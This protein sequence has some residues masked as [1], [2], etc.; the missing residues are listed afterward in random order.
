MNARILLAI[1]ALAVAPSFASAEEVIIRDRVPDVTIERPPAV[2]IERPAGRVEERGT[3][4]LR[5]DDCKRT[6]IH[7]ES[8][9]G[10]S[11]TVRKKECD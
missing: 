6:T 4:G 10:S 11:T 2:T 1:A 5:D 7:K 8:S 3:T 9:D